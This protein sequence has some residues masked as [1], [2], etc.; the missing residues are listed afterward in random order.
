MSVFGPLKQ[1]WKS[2]CRKWRYEHNYEDITKYNICQALKDIIYHP[3][4]SNDIKSGFKSCGIYPFNP[5]N[6]DYLKCIKVKHNTDHI[7]SREIPKQVSYLEHLESHIESDLLLSFRD[8]K[9]KG[10]DW[11]GDLSASM[12]YDVWLKF[13]D[14]IHVGDEE[15]AS[16]NFLSPRALSRKVTD[17]GKCPAAVASTSSADPIVHVSPGRKSL[18]PVFESA[19]FWPGDKSDVTNKRKRKFQRVP[20]VITSNQGK[21]FLEEK[22]NQ[23]NQGEKQST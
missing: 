14:E 19:C 7:S 4:I 9:S 6:V 2:F 12:L 21:I 11:Q 10:M 17:T 3:S 15:K 18:I 20:S 23:K 1:R 8:T 22:E 13:Q 16:E 5:D